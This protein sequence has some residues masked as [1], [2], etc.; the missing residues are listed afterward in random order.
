MKKISI[1][2]LSAVFTGFILTACTKDCKDCKSVTKDSSGN[3]IQEGTSSEYCDTAL[4]E[5][6]SA[7]PV[8]VGG[9]TTAWVCE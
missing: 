9:N 2:L 7:D 8:T 4:D 6:E 5:K 1:I 3:I